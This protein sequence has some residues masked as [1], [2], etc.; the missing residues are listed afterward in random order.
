MPFT[1]IQEDITSL[2]TD[3]IVNA[4]NTQL[5]MGG[6]V[7]GAIFSKAGAHELQ[8]YCDKLAPIHTGEAVITPGFRLKAKYIIHT[9]GPIYQEKQKDECRRLL[10]ACY[11]NSL[12]LAEKNHCESIAFPLISAGIYGYPKEE[13]IAIATS[14]IKEFL[15][16]S[17]MHVYLTIFGRDSITIQSRLQESL[18]RYLAE[19]YTIDQI[20][21]A[22][23]SYLMKSCNQY[24]AD[25]L[26]EYGEAD[27]SDL[28]KELDE[29]FNEALF[30]LIDAK[31]MRD[32]EVYKRANIDRKLFSKIRSHK[33]YIPKK[34]TILALCIALKLNLKETEDLLEKAGYA[35]SHSS[36]FDVIMEYFIVHQIYDIYE[37]NEVLFK[38]DQPL[39]G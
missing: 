12:G 24:E 30:R 4:A 11:R 13:A 22:F 17:D 38:Y 3:A 9:A 25:E 33:N 35:L 34:K 31:G 8:E 5:L 28:L 21:A 19:N 20:G 27:F 10:N 14:S 37:I 16:H 2:K 23:S 1:I 18:N 39:L 29:P 32:V 36:Q 15:L 26:T 6:G 7:C